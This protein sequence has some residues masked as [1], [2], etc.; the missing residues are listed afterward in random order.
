MNKN[1]ESTKPKLPSQKT[2]EGTENRRDEMDLDGGK[3]RRTV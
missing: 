1:S 3:R 2:E